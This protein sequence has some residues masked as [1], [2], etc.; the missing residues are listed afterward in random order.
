MARKR[1]RPKPDDDDERAILGHV[2]RVGWAVVT[3]A[4]DDEGPG[5]AFT[6]GLY[7]TYGHPEVI[8]VGQKPQAQHSLLNG[9]G[10][11]V[12]GGTRFDPE[13]PANGVFEG[14]VAW[15]LSVAADRYHDYLGT[16]N[17]FYR[18]TDYPAL[19]CVWPDRFARFPWF[20]DAH[21]DFRAAQPLLGPVP[22]HDN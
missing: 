17:W 19:Q 2:D 10:F 16:A 5:F 11:Q 13:R 7:E 4:E 18:G 12:K 20:P 14:Y 9:I 6:V 1:K 22:D 21:P 15:F 8:L 3:I